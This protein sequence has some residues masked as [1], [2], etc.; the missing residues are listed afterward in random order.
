[1]TYNPL[2]H[3][4]QSMRLKGYDYG[5][6]GFYFI[7]ICI[8][9]QIH[10]F[11][12]IENER[13]NLADAG[14]V[15]KEC[16][17]DIPIHFPHVKLHNFIIMPNHVHGIIEIM[18]NIGLNRDECFCCHIGAKNFSPLHDNKNQR[19]IA[20]FASPTKTVGSIIRGFKIGVTKW[21]RQNTSTYEVWQRGYYDHIIYAAA[22]YDR[23]SEYIQNNPKK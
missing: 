14:K 10:L 18:Q 8:K 19:F 2:I 17:L 3:N 15:A 22:S 1:M 20:K 11:G 23:I 12:K 5:R 6:E 9:G 13:M 7:T 16:W 4:R 21:I